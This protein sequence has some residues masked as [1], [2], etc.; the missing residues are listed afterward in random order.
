VSYASDVY[1]QYEL[2]VAMTGDLDRKLAAHLDKGPDQEDLT[3]AYWTPYAGG[4]RFTAVLHDVAIPAADERVLDGN[5][6]F[7]SKYLLRVLDELP[8]GCGIALLHS[9]LGPGWQGMSDDDV[10]AERDR[11]AAAVAGRT[12]LPLVGLTRG[13]DGTWSGRLWTRRD[14]NDYER[15]PVAVVRVAGEQLRLSFHPVLLPQPTPRPSQ[16]ATISVWGK[17]AQADL[18][19]TRIGIVGLGSVGSI[20]AETLSRIGATSLTFIDHDKIE[21]RNLD[22][23]VAAVPH[24]AA[25][26]TFKTTVARRT[27]TASTTAA[28][29]DVHEYPVSLLTETGLAAALDCDVIFSCVDRPWPRHLLN[30]IAYTHLIPVID[31]GILAKVTREGLPLHI[32]WRIQTVGPGR[33]CLVCLDALRR[34]DIALDRDGKLDDPDYLRGLS[35]TDRQRYARRNVFAFSLAVAA[36][37][38]LHLAGLVAGTS[39]I[40]GIGPQHYHAYPGE[41]TVEPTSTCEPDCEYAALTASAAD[42]TSNLNEQRLT[43]AQ[44]GRRPPKG[45]QGAS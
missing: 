21:E 41:M 17:I 30:T 34:S 14:R 37:E 1:A 45:P 3:F 5:V 27:A 2:S 42:L 18:T 11:L 28:H 13:T 20:V 31:G 12:G 25:S 19:R 8:A 43:D 23:T 40:S 33:R 6:S 32:D 24:D 44:H 29:L 36:H 4:R 15:R 38:V 10:T 26:G 7:T 16:T 22:R 35:E 9:H 39:R